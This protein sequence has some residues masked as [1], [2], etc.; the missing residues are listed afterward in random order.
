M[1]AALWEAANKLRGNVEP[2]EYKHVVLSLIFLKYASDRFEE[3]KQELINEGK[4]AYVDITEFYTQKSI[5][6]IPETSRW[7]YIMSQAKQPDIALKIDTA[8]YNIEQKNKTLKGALPDNYYSRLGLDV[9]KLSSLLDELNKIELTKDKEQDVMGR[10]YEYFLSNFA[11]QEGKGKGEFYTPKC[12]V[13]LI[14]EMIEPFKGTIYDPCCGSGGMFVQSMKFVQSHNGNTREIAVYGQEA[15]STTMK[16]AKM[17]LAIRGINSDLGEIAVSTFTND[18]HKDKKFDYIMAN[19]PFNQK[20]WREENE[21]TDDPRWDGYPVPPTSNANY[22]WILHIEYEPSAAEGKPVYFDDLYLFAKNRYF[23]SVQVFLTSHNEAYYRDSKNP[24]E[25]VPV[26]GWV[27]LCD[28]KKGGGYLDD[29][30][31]LY[32]I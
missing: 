13:N 17:N 22:G 14:A 18:Q 27:D 30:T 29:K 12:I 31:G 8:L 3:R 32:G 10:V 25:K 19:P 26:T 6:Y 23:D 2:A 28:Y 4:G 9:S 11:L 5:F 20:S 24:I 7:S 16:L 15:T 1:E 21:L